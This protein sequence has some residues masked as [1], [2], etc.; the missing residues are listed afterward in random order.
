M[1][2]IAAYAIMK[3]EADNIFAFVDQFKGHVDKLVLLDTG[4]EDNTVDLARDLEQAHDFIQVITAEFR[5]FS[6]SSARNMALEYASKELSE[7]DLVIWLDLDERLEEG[8][9]S[10]LMKIVIDNQL[11]QRDCPFVFKTNMIFS[12]RNGIPTM[13]YLQSKIHTVGT[14]QWQYDCH[15]ILVQTSTRASCETI[16][17]GINVRHF[18]N[19]NKERNYLPLLLNDYKKRPY[20]L[21]ALHYLAREYAYQE[22]WKTVASLLGNIG[23]CKHQVTPAGLIDAYLLEVEASIAL[24]NDYLQTLYKALS[25]IPNHAEVLLAI[26]YYYHG[27]QDYLA[28]IHWTQVAIKSLSDSTNPYQNVIYNKQNE[29]A[30]QLYDIAAHS[31]SELGN[32]QQALSYY[33]ILYQEFNKL[34]DDDTSQ[35]VKNNLLWLAEQVNHDT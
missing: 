26:S 5:P 20:D 8:W 28:S 12:E 35:R 29:I 13:E 4:S 16:F 32:Y 15:E 33:G 6:F 22:D 1:F 14:H 21:R 18:P 7:G 10:K 2:K 11:H 31:F 30:W 34:L 24:G 19:R 9:Y 27:K 3:N 25:I 23:M 17:S